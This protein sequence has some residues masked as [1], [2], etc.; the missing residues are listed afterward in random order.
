MQDVLML[1][2]F[3]RPLSLY[4][5]ELVKGTNKDNSGWGGEHQ[6]MGRLFE[7]WTNI[8]RVRFAYRDNEN[9]SELNFAPLGTKYLP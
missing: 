8:T 4:S 2:R 9:L 7:H 6:S 1:H 5:L 3:A